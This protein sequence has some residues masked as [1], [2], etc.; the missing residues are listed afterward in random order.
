MAKNTYLIKILTTYLAVNPF[1]PLEFHFAVIN[2]SN[3][4]KYFTLIH[5]NCKIFDQ[6]IPTA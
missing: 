2:P 5:K 4:H 3:L 1:L 6:C